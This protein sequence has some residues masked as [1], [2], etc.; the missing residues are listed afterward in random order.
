M[1]RVPHNTIKSHPLEFIY[2]IPINPFE[3]YS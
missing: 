1:Q 3:E 2:L